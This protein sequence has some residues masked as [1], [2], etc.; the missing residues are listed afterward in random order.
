MSLQSAPLGQLPS[1]SMP[2]SIPQ[3]YAKP[4]SIWQQA[5]ANLL[6]SAAGTVATQGAQ[7]L[8]SQDH[9]AE[10]GQTPRSGFGRLMQ[11][12][13]SDK[14]AAQLREQQFMGNQAENT[15]QFQ[16]EQ[17]DLNRMAAENLAGK[18]Q[19]ATAFNQSNEQAAN[20]YQRQLSDIEAQRRLQTEIGGRETNTRLEAQLRAQ[21]PEA[22]ARGGL[23]KAEGQKYSKEADFTQHMLD[24]FNKSTKGGQGAAVPVTDA[25]RAAM[26][27][28][29]Q[30]AGA[31]SIADPSRDYTAQPSDIA[32]YL[33][34]GKTPQ[35]IIDMVG[36]NS[37]Q[38]MTNLTAQNKPLPDITPQV[39]PRLAALLQQLGISN[40]P[41]VYAPGS[42]DF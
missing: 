38:N 6:T 13:V 30:G 39:D 42:M 9:A 16:S 37:L 7:N 8:L 28:L 22:L 10:F 5:L 24:M 26:G 27:A 12:V 3:Q 36:P 20:A 35:Q 40:V 31:P 18:A 15:R 29:R 17:D 1:M 23:Y 14:E 19:D 2:Y 32:S 34:Q 41:S 4:A 21:D 33:A 25:D 11:P